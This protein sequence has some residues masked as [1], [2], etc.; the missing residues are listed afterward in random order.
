MLHVRSLLSYQPPLRDVR[1]NRIHPCLQ[2]P[3]GL[4]GEQ[5]DTVVIDYDGRILDALKVSPA[6]R[7]GPAG[8]GKGLKSAKLCQ[9]T[10]WQCVHPCP[11]SPPE[12][13]V[14]AQSWLRGKKELVASGGWGYLGCSNKSGG[15]ARWQQLGCGRKGNDTRALTC[16]TEQSPD[17]FIRMK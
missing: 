5:G 4:K 11:V 17:L 12:I 15:G 14:L 6:P 1:L 13:S 10:L 8:H 3:P 16:P 9:V 2:G 7:L